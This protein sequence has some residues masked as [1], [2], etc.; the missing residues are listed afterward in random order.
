MKNEETIG[1]RIRRLRKARRWTQARL[2]EEAG[3]AAKTISK[4]ETETTTPHPRTINKIAYAFDMH[5]RELYGRAAADDPR[6]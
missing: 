1:R 5:P 2:A 4:I 6:D 3:L